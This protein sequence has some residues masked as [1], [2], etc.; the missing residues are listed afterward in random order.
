MG[1]SA[2]PITTHHSRSLPPARD[3]PMTTP[4]TAVTQGLHVMP[5]DDPI[6]WLAHDSTR[7]PTS[8]TTPKTRYRTLLPIHD[9]IGHE[10]P[11]RKLFRISP[12][13]RWGAIMALAPLLLCTSCTSCETAPADEPI[14]EDVTEEAPEWA[15]LPRSTGEADRLIEARTL[16]PRPSD[17]HIELTLNTITRQLE[18]QPSEDLIVGHRAVVAHI[19]SRIDAARLERRDAFIL[20][21]SYHDSAG[22]IRAFGRLL[23][24]N[25]VEGFT[26]VVIEQFRSDGRWGGVPSDLQVGDSQHLARALVDGSREA[27]Q[28]L[29]RSQREQNYTA[30][31]Y[32]SLYDVV[33]LLPLARAASLSVVGCDM[34]ARLQQ[35]LEN[36]GQRRL[37]RLRELHCLFSLNDS[38]STT[39]PRGVAMLWGAEHV[40]PEN[41]RRFLPPETRALSI[42]LVGERPNPLHLGGQLSQRLTVNAPLLVPIDGDRE[43][44][45]LI[46]PDSRLGGD[47]ERSRVVV[48][49][50][51]LGEEIEVIVDTDEAVTVS[52]A[53]A[54]IEASESPQRVMIQRPRNSTPLPFTA[55][56][57]TE[58]LVGNIEA[59]GV[60]RVELSLSMSQ[61]RTR[62]VYFVNNS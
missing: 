9:G 43:I 58:T 40:N 21:G 54:M 8:P 31:R 34:P 39:V 33:A 13:H 36:V 50:E 48:S 61:S 17:P 20:V 37:D 38:Q 14:N 60:I 30:W 2:C 49:Q 44:Y 52:V 26:H 57:E 41:F 18:K 59:G 55:V 1:S 23:G 19:D 46:L 27:W 3:N 6:A 47:V 32:D 11:R 12:S 45:A 24:P 5:H 10:R 28:T 53:G 56:N 22:Q 35:R 15:Q 7:P 16:R 51:D 42:F 62:I 25:G 4:M 29:E